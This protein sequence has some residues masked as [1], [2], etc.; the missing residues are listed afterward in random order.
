V[1]RGGHVAGAR[2]TRKW[3]PAVQAAR[4]TRQT[5]AEAGTGSRQA[6]SAR[7]RAQGP[8]R[9]AVA[10]T[11]Q[12]ERRRAFFSGLSCFF[13]GLSGFPS[14]LAFL[15]GLPG[16]PSLPSPPLLFALS[17][18]LALL[19]SLL[20]A[21]FSLAGSAFVS[22]APG[23]MA[24]GPRRGARCLPPRGSR[25]A[26]H[27]SCVLVCCTA[28]SR[29]ML[30]PCEATRLSNSTLCDL[31]GKPACRDSYGRT[32]LRPDHFCCWSAACTELPCAGRSIRGFLSI[33]CRLAMGQCCTHCCTHRLH[34]TPTSLQFVGP[35]HVPS[36][37]TTSLVRQLS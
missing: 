29:M 12:G 26:A 15:S 10:G 20:L 14:A 1:K 25:A 36:S 9:E 8:R 31:P 19:P 17:L 7:P 16:L 2:G 3:R 35:C 11:T 34:I 24:A 28:V 18:L 21:F 6:S 4:H 33:L 23:A 32:S 27:Y 13:S 5:W 37:F 30:F 22:S